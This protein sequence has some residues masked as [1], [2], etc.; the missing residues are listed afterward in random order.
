MNNFIIA[1]GGSVPELTDEAILTAAA[2]GPV[3]VN[4]GNTACKVPPA[5][6]YIRKMEAAGQLGKKKKMARC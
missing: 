1:V 4:M 5:A 6:D 3:Q 2:I